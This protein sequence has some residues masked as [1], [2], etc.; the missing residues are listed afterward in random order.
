MK[1][2]DGTSFPVAVCHAGTVCWVDD[3]SHAPRCDETGAGEVCMVT[4]GSNVMVIDPKSNMEIEVDGT[5]A[6]YVTGENHS[7]DGAVLGGGVGLVAGGAAAFICY[8]IE[9]CGA[10][11][12]VGAIGGAALGAATGGAVVGGGIG[13]FVPVKD[14]VHLTS[15]QRATLDGY[16][17]GGYSMHRAAPV[18][19]ST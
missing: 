15:Y 4:D 19:I 7:T 6:Y 10:I 17:D 12:T 2:P 16:I 9:P 1:Y 5:S 13:Y 8:V 11:A 14:S 3:L 18:R